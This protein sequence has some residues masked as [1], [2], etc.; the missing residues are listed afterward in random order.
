MIKRYLAEL[1]AH[2]RLPGG[3]R[4]R[5]LSEVEDHL[6]CAAAELSATGEVG[7]QDAELQ[8]IQR[9]GP[10]PELA[11]RFLEQE[12]TRSGLR[13]AQAT[14]VLGV[15]TGLLVSTAPG[16]ALI[17]TVLPDGLVEFL[18]AQVA[19][20]AGA[21][22]FARGWSSSPEGGPHGARLALVLRGTLVVLACAGTG[23]AY[24]VV[25][26]L[27]SGTVLSLGG[28]VALAVL[29]SGV[30]ATGFAAVRGWRLAAAAALP[31]AGPEQHD[32]LGDIQAAALLALERAAHRV[33]TLAAP[34]R[35]AASLVATLPAAL[36]H[37]APRLSAWLDLRRHPWRFALTVS[38]VAGLAVAVGHGV[39]EGATT[40]HLPKQLLAGGLIAS[41]E[42]AAA[43][44]GFAVLGRYLGLR[45]D[46]RAAAPAPRS[47]G[48]R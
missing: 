29:V 31:P 34:L 21:V 42:A 23:I 25:R 20:V 33:P 26:A 35:R 10:A 24:G 30:A 27:L 48:A 41:I 5:I 4:R 12:A 17:G 47:T 11:Q 45:S 44:L 39:G 43:L 9:F 1:Q 28:W 32:I 7:P 14:G 16:R 2:L 22:T 46:T 13:A 6:A 40:D 38:I 8:A 19:L 36:A 3:R 18:L 15:L 37:R